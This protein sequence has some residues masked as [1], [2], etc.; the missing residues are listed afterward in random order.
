MSETRIQGVDPAPPDAPVQNASGEA[1]LSEIVSH[2]RVEF[3]DTDMARI[4]HFSRFLDFMESTEHEFLRRALGEDLQVH[5]D[6]EGHEIGWP[7]A[8]VECEYHSPARLGDVLEIRAR[9]VRLRPGGKS[10]T[11]RFDVSCDERRIA[12]GRIT[13]ICCRLGGPKLE[14]IPIPDFLS[15]RIAEHPSAGNGPAEDIDDADAD[16]NTEGD[17]S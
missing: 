7:R 9:V 17:R 11:Y 1:P 14:A 4:V 6:Y 2:R 15:R 8:K 16:K 3:A 13:A 10:I 12:T 5:F